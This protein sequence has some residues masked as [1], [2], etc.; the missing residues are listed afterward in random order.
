MG[1]E[2]QYFEYGEEEI[3]HLRGACPKLAW[4]IDAIGPIRR[5]VIPDLYAALVNS[6]ISQQISGAAARTIWGRFLAL[7]GEA[8]PEAVATL[9]DAALQACGI[10]WRKVG[11]IREL[12]R[13]VLGGELDLA[14]V[15]L[16]DDEAAIAELVRLPGIGRWTAEM[17][18]IFSLQ[19][20]NVLSAG[21]MALA[22]GMRMLYRHRAITPKLHAKYLRRYTPYAT[23]ASFYLWRVPSLPGLVD[24]APK[25]K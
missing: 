12:T 1:T 8:R 9:E 21:D 3:A 7:A 2:T 24:L 17:M 25:R 16:M 20:P 18:L 14:A 5:E 23:V 4:A 19:R 15:A 10:S 13:R 11:Y 22:R 6:I